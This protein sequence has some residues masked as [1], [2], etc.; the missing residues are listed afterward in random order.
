MW[1]TWERGETCTGFSWE[2][3]GERGHVKDQG[4]DGRIGSKWT[5]GRL[6]GGGG[7]VEWI[8]LAGDRDCWHAVV[9]A[10]DK[11]SGSDATE[12]I[13]LYPKSTH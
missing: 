1:H 4:V 8:H 3:Q 13:S 2:N 6:A 12:F 9:N 7:V 5:L 11:P 10:G